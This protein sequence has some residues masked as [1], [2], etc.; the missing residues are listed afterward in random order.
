MTMKC[1]ECNSKEVRVTV[2]EHHG[3]ETWRYCRC[4]DCN[5]KFKTIETYAK[6][7]PGPAPGT[8]A[9]PN[10]VKRGE[11]NDFAVLTEQNVIDIRRLASDNI[12]Y[13]II[14]KQYGIHKDTVYRIVN[15]KT[16][17]HV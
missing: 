14:A 6:P 9:H 8:K 4:L 7:K 11:Q 12:K 3:N 16:W 5:C 17:N 1:R 2:T 10:T 13:T 15:Y